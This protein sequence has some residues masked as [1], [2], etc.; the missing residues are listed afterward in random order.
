[1]LLAE[2]GVQRDS[3][4][5]AVVLIWNVTRASLGCLRLASGRM[6]RW[7]LRT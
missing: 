7:L 5:T 3:K 1:M 4:E 2:V 6:Q